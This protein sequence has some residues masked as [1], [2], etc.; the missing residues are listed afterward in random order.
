MVHF[1]C[2]GCTATV[3]SRAASEPTS[4]VPSS[5]PA[6]TVAL[7]SAA[8]APRQW[9]LVVAKNLP[10]K[11]LPA[12]PQAPF[13]HQWLA[14]VFL[15]VS[16]HEQ[17]KN[18]ALRSAARPRPT[19]TCCIFVPLTRALSMWRTAAGRRRQRRS[20]GSPGEPKQSYYQ[21]PA[22]SR[23]GHRASGEKKREEILLYDTYSKD[24]N[25]HI[26]C[27]Q[28]RTINLKKSVF[29]SLTVVFG[30]ISFLLPLGAGHRTWPYC[31]A[32]VLA[33]FTR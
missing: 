9:R 3:A 14:L 28:R 24:Q 21:L 6:L 31:R 17:K 8:G 11:Y 25:T 13:F 4:S 5:R 7:P 15:L 19:L 2:S 1:F 10:P 32:L 12:G 20:G 18:P 16:L 30:K 26:R 27:L 33:V 22:I 23:D 29:S